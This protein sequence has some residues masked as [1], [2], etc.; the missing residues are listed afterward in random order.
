MRIKKIFNLFGFALS[1]NKVRRSQNEVEKLLAQQALAKILAGIQ[2]VSLETAEL[3]LDIDDSIDPALVVAIEPFPLTQMLPVLEQALGQSA[4]KVFKRIDEAVAVASLGQVHFAVLKNGQE[5]AVKIRYPHIADAINTELSLLE[6]SSDIEAV[7]PWDVEGY[8]TELKNNMLRELDYLSEADRQQYF[9]EKVSVEGLST[10]FIYKQLCSERV[11][12]QTR[13]KGVLINQITNWSQQDREAVGCILLSTLLTGL[14]IAGEVHGD[15]DA[16]NI[17]FDHDES[18]MPVV[19]LLD[20]GCTI[21]VSESRRLLLLQLIIASRNQ[22]AINP[23]DCFVALGFDVDKLAHISGSLPVLCQ[24]LFEPFLVDHSFQIGGWNLE[25]KITELLGDKRC[26]FLSAIPSDLVLL[27]RAF[28]G[29]I[30]QLKQLQVNVNCWDILQQSAGDRLMEQAIKI[31]LPDNITQNVTTNI[32]FADQAEKLCVLVSK[33]GRMTASITMSADAVL[34]LENI[35]P[36][37][38]TELLRKNKAIDLNQIEE[39]L[40]ANGLVP[41][42]IFDFDN[43]EK[44]YKVWLE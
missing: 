2:G 35:M 13:A 12:V 22:S 30:Q 8:K 42:T 4:K 28:R 17:L 16:D 7:K 36:E 32:S 23:L 10:P 27:T 6:L 29:L 5:V 15:P 40:K 11:L 37:S 41:Q 21:P 26:W 9:A 31:T 25:T 3:F 44:N 20:Y 24:F 39:N 18:G 19:N 1:A 14:F 33:N 38:V 43:G 34:D